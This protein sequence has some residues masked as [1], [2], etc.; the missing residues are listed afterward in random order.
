MGDNNFKIEFAN[1]AYPV[2]VRFNEI[3]PDTKN[4]EAEVLSFDEII[5]LIVNS[6]AMRV[7]IDGRTESIVPGEGLL[8]N[9]KVSFK[10]HLAS[11][12]ACSYYLLAF[13]PAILFSDSKMYKKFVS[14][15]IDS[16]EVKLIKLS[17]DTL[18][19]ESVWDAVNRIIAA[20]L[21]CKPRFELV[22][23]SL[24]AS[25]WNSLLDYTSSDNVMYSGKNV[26]TSDERRVEYAIK[27]IS[28]NYQDMITLEDIAA[29][30]HL[31]D[32]ECCRCFKRVFDK[33]PINYLLE[34]RIFAALRILYKNPTAV[35]SIGDLCFS[36]GF[37]NPSYF[38]KVFKRYTG[39]TPTEYKK[40]MKRKPEMAER[41]Y[42][43]MQEDITLS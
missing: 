17:E 36:V 22:T 42:T 21:A 29:Y 26:P 14:P 6:G 5:V 1:S 12:E 43:D 33:S 15:F 34:Y 25:L 23:L 30:I 2:A 27:Y 18:R 37:N 24:L 32:S 41:I 40:L 38:N 7:I 31:S 3:N 20:N 19:D 16:R 39:C 4:S 35:E 8:I 9:S 13:N 10:Y 28:E 11:L